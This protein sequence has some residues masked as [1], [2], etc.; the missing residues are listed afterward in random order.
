MNGFLVGG[1]R[2]HWYKEISASHDTTYASYED[3]YVPSFVV[4]TELV[5]QHQI[6]ECA[7]Q[8]LFLGHFFVF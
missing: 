4:R 1:I 2:F 5:P 7:I 8:I 3:I 6:F